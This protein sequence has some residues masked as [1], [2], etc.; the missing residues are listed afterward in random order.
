MQPT[1]IDQPAASTPAHRKY[2]VMMAGTGPAQEHCHFILTSAEN[3]MQAITAARN[4]LGKNFSVGTAL[5]STNLRD[6]ANALED[7]ALLPGEMVNATVDPNL[8]AC[9]RE[10]VRL[11][12]QAG[13]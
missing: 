6:L 1:T 11:Q 9:I 7:F 5:D 10:R 3:T 12:T 2:V 4:A 13:F 8:D